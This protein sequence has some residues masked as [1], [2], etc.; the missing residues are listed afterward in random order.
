MELYRMAFS[1]EEI[2]RLL[3][4]PI[5]K[6]YPDRFQ[7]RVCAALYS[8]HFR[9]LEKGVEMPYEGW[10][11]IGSYPPAIALGRVAE[12]M[13]VSPEIDDAEWKDI[14]GR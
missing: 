3:G 9:R 6:H 2:G 10:I 1:E 5:D 14:E 4:I 11:Y 7:T 12:A 13:P 8:N